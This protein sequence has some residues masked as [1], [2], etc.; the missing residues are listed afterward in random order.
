MWDSGQLWISVNGGAYADVGIDAFTANGYTDIAIIGNGIAKGQNGFGNTSAGYADGSYITTTANLGSFAAGDAISVRFVAL[1]DDCATGTNPN[2]VI[3][4][5]SSDQMA[6]KSIEGGLVAHWPM[7]EGSGDV[8]KDVVGGSMDSCRSLK[9]GR[10][11]KSAGVKDLQH[12]QTRLSLAVPIPSLPPAFPG[13]GGSEPRTVAFWVR[14]TDANA[15]YMAWG[16]NATARKWHIRANGASGVMRTEFAGGQNFATTSIIDGEWHHVA[17]VF[18]NGATEGEQILHY[19]DG[20]LD[21]Q[22]GGTSLTIDT[23]IVTDADIDWT[24]A[25]SAESYPVHIGGRLTHGWGNMLIGSMADVRIYNHGLSE[26]QIRAIFQGKAEGGMNLEGPTIVDF[27]DLSGDASYEFF[28]KAIKAGASTAI[29]GN[30]A[31]AF[32]L[33]Q[34]NEQGVFGT[35]VFGVAD[36]LFTAVEGKSVASVF[37]RDVHVVLVNDTA[38]GETR[39]Y[40]DGDHVGVLAGNFEL[41]GEGKV[42]GARIEAN[43]DPMGDGSVM[44]K[45]ATYDNALT[46]E[47]IAG[48]A[49]EVAPLPDLVDISAAGDGVVPTSDNHPAGEHAGLAVDDNDQTKYLNFDGANNNASGLTITTAGG[50]VS[51]LGL[52]SANDAPDRDPATFVLS[53]SNDGGATLTEIA[54]GDVPAFGARFERQEVRFANDA[55]Y[56]TYEL[57]FPTTAGSSTCCMQI[58]EIELLGTPTVPIVSNGSFEADDVPE[59]PGYGAI[60]AWTGGSGINDGGPFGDNGVIPDGAKLGFIQGTK[61][62][63]QQLTGLEAGAEYVLAFYYNARNCCGGTIGFTVSVGGEELGS[64]SDV[65]PVGGENAYNS[66]SYYFVAAGTEAELVFSATAAGDATLLLDAV[67]VSRAGEGP[68]E[69][70]APAEL[71]WSVGLN[72]DGWPAGDGGGPNTT[73]VQEKGANELPGNPASPEVAQQGDDDYYWAGLYSTVIAGNGDYTPVGLVEA[74]EESAERAFAG[75]DNDLRYHFNLPESLEPT[76]RLTVSYDALNLHTGEADSRYGIEVYVNNVQV[77]SEIVIREAEL[78]QTYATDPFT[79]ADV[80]AEVGSGYDNI[81]TLKGVNYNAE[82]GGNWMGIDYVQLSQAGPATPSTILLDFA[83]TGANSAGASPDPWISI[84]NL[85]MDEAVDLGGGVT[86]T[87]LDDGFNPNN[88]AQPGEGAEYDGVS[89]PQE[90]R[91][92]YF[93][94]IADAAGTTA[95][96]RIDGLAAGTYN[97]TVFEGRTT[98]A[99]QFAKIWTGE[100]PATE[101]T[102]DFAKGSATVTVTVG[103][104]ESLWY[105]HLEDGSGG[106]SG[107]MIRQASDT[108]ALSIVNNGD[109]SV[110]VTFE[111]TL[112]AANSVNGP[113]ADVEG[114]VSPQIIPA[115]EAMQFGRA[116]K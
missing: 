95:R 39:L 85:V 46:N 29:A 65:E 82:G 100:E 21:P 66:A 24:N 89:V 22:A 73:F 101:N 54:S 110:T 47:Q 2:W 10:K 30:D 90:A 64:V 36:N 91:N 87:A 49:D 23:E 112:Q 67:S 28:F 26:D 48:L 78:G 6:I 61:A 53:G 3:A 41:A 97:V 5:V 25:N 33:D 34:W 40:V 96:M 113:W 74:N 50:V 79:L 94:K 105:M 44:H 98:D 13:I 51:G 115:S 19:I 37:D 56:T 60:T 20:V 75:I 9:T 63:S 103:A 4:S 11:R 16:S 111:G 55:A 18:P 42:M 106:V 83:G 52:T 99:S 76:D 59:W 93:F 69:T 14:T 88:P 68:A 102:G 109:G 70:P 43:T 12:R 104:G 71:P 7:N 86:I 8:F 45:W 92:D 108:P 72:D 38:A 116:V 27:G 80:N 57:I 17:S 31:F 107:M 35:T 81:I 62:L 84:N 32:K 77:Q 1:Y 15:V 114:A 58:A